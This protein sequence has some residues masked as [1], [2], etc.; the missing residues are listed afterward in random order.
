M[1][2][3]DAIFSRLNLQHLREFLLDGADSPEVSPLD[4]RRRIEEAWEPVTAAIRSRFPDEEAYED[5]IQK[6]DLY[7]FAIQNVYMEVGLKCGAILI[8]RLL[9]GRS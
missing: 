7:T 8:A 9:G 4:Y 3:F 6:I 2:E 1:S 5:V